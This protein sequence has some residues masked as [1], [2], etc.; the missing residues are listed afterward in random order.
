[1]SSKR[2]RIGERASGLILAL[3][4]LAMLAIIA[5]TFIT[6]MRI[7]TRLSKVY[8]DELVTEMLA[9]GVSNYCLAVLRDDQDRTLYKYENRDQAVGGRDRWQG[10]GNYSGSDPKAV[11]DFQMSLP[12]RNTDWWAAAK[13]RYATA[14]SNDVW[15]HSA[16]EGYVETAL[17]G[18]SAGHREWPQSSFG[19]QSY[20]FC[21]VDQNDQVILDPAGQN[22]PRRYYAYVSANHNGL[23]DDMD[24]WVDPNYRYGPHGDPPVI[25]WY[26]PDAGY[27][28][29]YALTT[30]HYDSASFLTHG[31]SCHLHPGG[32]LTG[33]F[34]LPGGL[35][36]RWAAKMG[37]PEERY[38]NLNAAGN[39]F[40]NASYLHN[41]DSQGLEA[42]SGDGTTAPGHLGILAWKGY[43]G[44]Y[45][46]QRGGFHERFNAVQYS[47]YQIDPYRA[48]SLAYHDLPYRPTDGSSVQTYCGIK[49][50]PARME[51]V[52][53]EWVRERWG[54][55]GLPADGGQRWRIRWRRDG[56]TYCKIPSPEH[57]TG[58]DYYFG[59]AE[60]L[61]HQSED[62]VPGASRVLGAMFAAAKGNMNTARMDFGRARG[63]LSTYGCDTILRGRIWPTEGPPYTSTQG[64]WRHI[65]ILRKVN[66]NMP[67]AKG[68]ENLPGEDG[69]LKSE[70]ADRRAREQ[71]RLYHML[72]AMLDW[73]GTPEASHEA[74]Q[75]VASLSDMVDR[76]QEETYYAAD[77]GNWALGVEKHPVI[78]EI[79][80]YSRSKA[81]TPEYELFR[82]RV[83][84][85]NP[86]ENIPWIRD[87]DEAYDI[88]EYILKI[89]GHTYRLGDL[90]RYSDDPNEALGLVDVV[91]KIGA[92]GMYGDP[93]DTTAEKL[94][95]GR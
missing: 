88:S 48:V 9:S 1:M 79:V 5:T 64:D 13:H 86:W 58:D 82:L 42:T 34:R 70:W 67:G 62:I 7:N 87:E 83:E 19:G 6:L 46:Y 95:W 66:I 74:C 94:S 41:M 53:P 81:N 80:F 14:A 27:N 63:Y 91:P 65:D 92:G 36:W 45:I 51:S 12:G 23:D 28:E 54:S 56:A 26:F 75:V 47:P 20:D 89:G 39:L 76:D 84:L 72:K 3:G 10:M 59:A 78:N 18:A 77:D 52:A 69:R 61:N 43:P 22:A 17:Y 71:R 24:G 4:V 50:N 21:I 49:V 25:G 73:T 44:E 38:V 31:R 40:K 8:T 2:G 30:Y 60:A 57:P 16:S 90:T 33:T 85:Y 11:T 32:K 68:G 55:D 35:F 37:V 15:Y 29:V 93:L